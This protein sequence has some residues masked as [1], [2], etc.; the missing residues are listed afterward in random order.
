MLFI[1]MIILYARNCNRGDRIRE[2]LE[3]F[4]TTDSKEKR[5]LV[6][7]LLWGLLSSRE[8]LFNH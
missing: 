6:E 8:F 4:A 2:I 5:P 7:D 3:V 1:S